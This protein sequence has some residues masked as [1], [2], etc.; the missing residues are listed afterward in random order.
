MAGVIAS[1]A[2]IFSRIWARSD[3]DS[4][5]PPTP[6]DGQRQLLVDVST[7][8]QHD[9]RTGIQRVVR[10]VLL[11]LLDV[12]GEG[13]AVRPVFAAGP[14]DYRYAP[15]DVLQSSDVDASGSAMPVS[16]KA[17]DVFLGLDLSAHILPRCGAMMRRWRARGV[18][19][20]IVVY[21]LLPATHPD[22]FTA[23]GVRHFRRWLRFIADH[24]DGVLCISDHVAGEFRRWIGTNYPRKVEGIAVERLLLGADLQT[25]GPS[26][27]LP[28]GAEDFLSGMRHA[29]TILMV[30]T[31][32]PR[33]AYELALAAM[34]HLWSSCPDRDWRLVIVG[35]AG[36]KT[37]DLQVRL[38]R[39]PMAGTQLFH[40]SD[41]SDEYLARLY[42]ACRCVLIAS[43]D[44]GFGLPVIEAQR[45]GRRVLARDLPVFRE[46]QRPGM[47]YFADD[48][49]GALAEA[50]VRCVDAGALREEERIDAAE[51]MDWQVATDQL[52]RT[53]GLL[54][55][56]Q[57]SGRN[58]SA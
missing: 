2:V 50:I 41:A 53:L 6:E 58:I 28:V 47:H 55:L 19:C 36:W 43:R 17:G 32:E 20:H 3:S 24:A 23:G 33:K 11:H 42:G 7:I 29:P 26:R 12:E 54:L 52:V 14:G 45:F 18:A 57:A 49:P 16:V 15:R 35:K 13:F 9:A 10:G 37:E 56:P 44:E 34:E 48:A 40:L 21:D 38:A 30:G 51:I 1:L 25:T 39:H 22:W 8:R 46:L 4:D 31:I 27:G 5:V